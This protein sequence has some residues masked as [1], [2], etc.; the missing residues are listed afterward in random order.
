MNANK[1][2]IE[3]IKDCNYQNSYKD[4]IMK[5]LIEL[6]SHKNAIFFKT[7]LPQSHNKIIA[8]K[9]PLNVKLKGNSYEIKLT[10]YM[11][12]DFPEKAP[13]LFIDNNG[14]PLLAVNPKNNNVNPDNFRVMTS[15]LFNWA[16]FTSIQQVLTEVINSF[17]MNFPI[18]KKKPT[19]ASINSNNSNNNSFNSNTNSNMNTGG[20]NPNPNPI[21]TNYNNNNNNNMWMGN[22]TNKAC[23]PIYNPNQNQINSNFSFPPHNINNNNNNIGPSINNQN[24]N[25]GQGSINN[26]NNNTNNNSFGYNNNSTNSN[27]I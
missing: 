9:Y 4:Y 14:D 22:T 1:N 11:P 2:I 7:V 23:P 20:F 3:L 6:S 25:Q 12:S 19:S 26:F 5:I 17:E 16:K 27:F 24:F 13:E 8:I 21:Q 10:I 18:Y 15:K